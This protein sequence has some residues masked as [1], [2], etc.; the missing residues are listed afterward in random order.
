LEKLFQAWEI[1]SRSAGK[2]FPRPENNSHGTGDAKE[3]VKGKTMIRKWNTGH[4]NDGGVWNQVLLAVNTT[5]NKCMKVKTQTGSL[6]DPEVIQLGNNIIAGATGKPEVSSGAVTPVMLQTMVTAAIDAFN[7]EGAAEDALNT[8]Y[9]ARVM[10]MTEL[11]NGINRFAIHADSVYNG[12]KLSLQA[13]GL[14][15]RKAPAPI[16]P[17]PAPLN[18]RS[19]PG[20]LSGTIRLDWDPVLSG[21]PQYFLE[22]AQSLSGPWTMVYT[23]RAARAL[24]VELTP[25]AE[26]FF[27]VRAHGKA[28]YSPWS[29]ITMNRAAW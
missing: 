14:N 19:A 16:G 23:G 11:R 26:Y 20:A 3:T 21:R 2:N 4:W 5:K 22:Y 9:T 1:V 29:D 12:D 10:A 25:G 6:L 27:R 13:V 15:V 24:S 18:L 7:D 17:L 8:A 28:G